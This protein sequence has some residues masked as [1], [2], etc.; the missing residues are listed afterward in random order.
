MPALNGMTER[1][2]T[3]DLQRN[4]PIMQILYPLYPRIEKYFM[5][6]H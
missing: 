2:E 1:R 3:P 6:I 4:R 5:M